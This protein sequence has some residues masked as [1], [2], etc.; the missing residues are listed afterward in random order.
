MEE[1]LIEKTMAEPQ[2]KGYSWDE[3]K[4]R[5]LVARTKLEIAKANLVGQ[6]QQMLS[7]ENT[8]SR[9]LSRMGSYV[10]YATA[11]FQAYK[12]GKSLWQLFRS[13]Q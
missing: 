5:R 2:W 13:K 12:W 3:L 8:G 11:A 7:S 6:Y 4:F 9:L 1:D 10:E